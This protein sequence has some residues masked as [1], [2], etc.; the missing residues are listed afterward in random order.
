MPGPLVRH[1]TGSSLTFTYDALGRKLTEAG[2]LGTATST[3]NI[4]GTR[5]TLPY[6]AAGSPRPMIAT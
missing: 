1:Q 4:D 3:W 2:P 6:P 5:A